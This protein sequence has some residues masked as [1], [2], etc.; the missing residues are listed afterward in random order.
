VRKG[1]LTRRVILD[2]AVQVA[3]QHGLGGLTIGQLAAHTGMSKSGLFAHFKAKESLQLQV[4]EHGRER[5]IDSVV[6]PALAAPRGLPRLRTLFDHWLAWADDEL[7]GGCLFVAAAAELDDQPGPARDSLVRSE[8]D[9]LET[10]A[11]I[12]A[13]AVAEG[14]FRDD[15]DVDQFAFELH[16]V[17]LTHHHARRLLQDERASERTRR[18][19]ESLIAAASRPT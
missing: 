17:M 8:R 14:E 1:E 4:L 3:S 16:G 18:A 9:W 2:D 6:R 12:A 19:F 7:K 11:T 15:L 5:F 13:T 10:V